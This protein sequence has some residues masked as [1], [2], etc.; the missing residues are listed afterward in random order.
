MKIT[1]PD[2]NVKLYDKPT[3]PGQ[4]AA[5]IGPG[6]AKAALGAKVD[7]Q[8][9]DLNRP[10]GQD[11]HLAIVTAP[12][13]DKKTQA[14]GEPDPEAMHLLRH[15]C[16]HVMAEAVQ[17]LWPE[18][19]LAYGP[20]AGQGFYYDLRLKSPISTDDFPK[21]ES[22]MQKIIK[23]DRPFTRYDL[24]RD[25]GMAKL[26]DEGNKYKIDNATRALQSGSET[27]SWYLTGKLNPED[28][29]A[30]CQN[31]T[32]PR[33][34]CW[35]DLCAGPHIP[36]TGRIGAFKIMS[37]ATSHW[38]GDIASDRFQRIYGTAF[39]SQAD[40]DAHLE[41]LE[42]ARKR[43]HRVVGQKLGLF[44]I[45]EMVGQG[46][47]LWKPR[48][49]IVRQQLQNFIAEH[50]DRQ[51][52]EQV[53]TPHIGKLDLYRTSGH[54]PYYQ[55]SQYP[56]L[57]SR[58]QI[59][60]LAD[61]NC[62]CAQLANMMK[63]GEIDGYL[64]KPMSCPMHLRIYASE[65]RS[66]RDLPIRL[67]EFAA[68]YRWEQSGEISGM[69]RVR[70][71]TQDDAHLFVIEDQLDEEINGCLS[72]VKIIFAT[73]G[74]TDYRVRVG[75]RDPDSRKYVGQPEQWDKAETACIKA[76]ESL[77]APFSQEPGEAAF[78]GPKIDFVVKDVIGR[79]WQLG[80][81]QV[82]YQLP[83][84]FNLEY[85]GS[86]NRAHRPVMIHR[87]PFGS[88]ERFIGVLIEH[89]NGAFP[90]WLAPQQIRV[91]PIS[92]KFLSYANHV[93]D[94]A[95]TR[96][97]R[98]GIDTGNERLGAK[99]KMAQEDQVPYMLVV[100][101]KD[102]QA[103]TVSVRHRS[104]GDLG[105]IGIDAFFKLADDENRNRLLGPR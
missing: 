8:L 34:R 80:T 102:E 24:D 105:A 25:T 35:E 32:A 31:M 63:D 62:S 100:G 37:V 104:N 40:L 71:L 47:I 29:D 49:A 86:D 78:Y 43:D 26:S 36:S 88:L 61:D 3:T 12:K 58:E 50:L 56:P 74:M 27:L 84:R 6:L 38:R 72:L 19:Q 22:E 103:K 55:E 17:Q 21:I 45:D 33:V 10:I 57:V 73:L 18:T 53:F 60:A 2:G 81:I 11:A 96:G 67:S 15:S 95:T 69:L 77:G 99:I 14:K 41:R 85:T 13:L 44:A 42:E 54:Y 23:E 65:K 83:E 87:A 70:G 20:P 97:F 9:I 90:L 51:G 93:L 64:L 79:S 66:Y 91:L 94:A 52:Y 28:G 92:D 5:D 16:A 30:W 75:L 82:D 48:G 68:V 7:G 59:K 39:F 1:L 76:A 89:F 46:L 101:G 98:V 4:V